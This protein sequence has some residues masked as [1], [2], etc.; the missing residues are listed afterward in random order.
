M[1][2]RKAR[3]TAA[4]LYTNTEIAICECREAHLPFLRLSFD[5]RATGNKQTT[6][7]NLNIYFLLIHHTTA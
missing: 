1:T 4:L 7:L 5:R 3:A 2:E 6:S